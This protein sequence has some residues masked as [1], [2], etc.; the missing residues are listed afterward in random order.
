MRSTFLLLSIGMRLMQASRMIW[1]G[2][3]PGQQWVLISRADASRCSGASSCLA[4]AVGF[5]EALLV[6]CCVREKLQLFAPS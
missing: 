5:D 2:P 1:K 3:R 4:L 6:V